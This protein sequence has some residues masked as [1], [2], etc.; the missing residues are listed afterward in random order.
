MSDIAPALIALDADVEIL[1]SEGVRRIPVSA[2]FTGN[3]LR[4]RTLA[5]G[6]IVRTVIVPPPPHG[7]GWGFHK[8]SIRGGLEFAMANM[9][10]A[11]HLG[12]DGKRCA[13][14][15][16]VVGAVSEGPLRARATEKTLVGQALDAQRLMEAA[17][18]AI[19]EI[20]P[21]PHHGFTSSYLKKNIRVHLRDTLVAALERGC[22]QEC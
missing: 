4:P 18:D 20:K 2:L 11:L 9:A 5:P 19:V 3:G 12:I 15:R 13:D 14:A 17:E 22:G 16:I 7:F 6:E 1:G 8:S 21:L 10:V